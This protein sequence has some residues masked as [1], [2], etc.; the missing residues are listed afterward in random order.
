VFTGKVASLRRIKDNVDEVRVVVFCCHHV[1]H[2][3]TPFAVLRFCHLMGLS[4]LC[5]WSL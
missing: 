3:L 5:E 1:L 2:N 4:L